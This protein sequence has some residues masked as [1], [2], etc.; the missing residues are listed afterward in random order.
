MKINLVDGW[1]QAWTWYS[2]H[3]LLWP[4]AAIGGWEIMPG[5]WQDAIPHRIVS[6]IAVSVLLSGMA[7]RL[8]EQGKP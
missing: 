6:A 8:V 7:G 3:A 2:M 1:H 5:A 4:A